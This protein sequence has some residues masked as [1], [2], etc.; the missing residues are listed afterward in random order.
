[1]ADFS[2]PVAIPQELN[3]TD[4]PSALPDCKAYE[5]RTAPAGGN[6]TYTLGSNSVIQFSLPRLERAF[7]QTKS[8]YITGR[9]TVV[10]A[11]GVAGTDY[12]AV[13]GSFYSLFSQYTLRSANGGVLDSI[14]QVGII[15]NTLL[16]LGVD[17]GAKQGFANNL[18][19]NQGSTL[20]SN[21]IGLK[22]NYAT[23][24]GRVLT[25]DFALPIFGVWNTS[26]YWPASNELLME[27]TTNSL[28]S[29]FLSITA[30]GTFTSATLSNL[31]FVSDVL[32]MSPA[33]YDWLHKSVFPSGVINLKSE[34]F[35]YC[36]YALSGGSTG[37]IDI[38]MTIRAKSIK[39]LFITFCPANAADAPLAA[40]NPNGNSICAVI[41]GQSIPSRPLQ[42]TKP[43]ECFT[44]LLTAMGS[45]YSPEK[46][47]SI[48]ITNYRVASTAYTGDAYAAYNT[49]VAN[50][51]TNQNY[52]P[53]VINTEQ[54]DHD[55]NVLFNGIS[56]AGS[57]SAV[58]R[59]DI[60]TALAAQVHN[61]NMF[62]N[63]DC[64]VSFDLNNNTVMT[65]Y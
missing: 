58:V 40:V 55:S 10:L 56:T 47:T 1:M 51:E 65:Y 13:A 26:H 61:C 34:T 31:E 11:G 35:S 39:R 37:I 48:N 8:S 42:L 64:I 62:A 57:T 52:F 44:K 9:C 20:W 16:N 32:E 29:A 33:S 15:A 54:L 2:T 24:A 46:S 50:N 27:W 43:A 53:I 6:S 25:L 19:L 38:P 36:S 17:I 28:A 63:Y 14:S 41:N 4:L 12:K 23:A 7:F 49:A 60:N 45:L 18:G 59:L 22:F 30:T 5:Y 3:F 21:N